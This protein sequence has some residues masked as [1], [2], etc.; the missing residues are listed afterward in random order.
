MLNS[1]VKP[2]K[3]VDLHI[4]VDKDILDKII[5]LAG[6]RRETAAAVIRRTLAAGL[7]AEIAES[8]LE[9]ITSAIRKAI[10]AE[11]K[12][13]ENRLAALGA[14]ASIAAGTSEHMLTTLFERSISGDISE[15]RRQAKAIHDEARKNAVS[16]LKQPGGDENA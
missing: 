13:T 9:T 5:T 1:G 11:L 16:G 7:N 3:L 14:K 6:T 4:R 15:K 2:E 10:R 12:S 8:S